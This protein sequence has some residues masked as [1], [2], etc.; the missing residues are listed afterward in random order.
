MT[1]VHIGYFEAFKSSNTLILEGDADG[2]RA[3]AETFRSLAAGTLD[4]VALHELPFMKVHHGVQVVA[5]RSTHDRGTRRADAE[6]VFYDPLAI[7]VLDPD[8]EDEERFVAV[9]LGS[10]GIILVVVYTL[11]G[12]EIRLISARRATRHEVKSYES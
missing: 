9:G 3:L 2:L 8:S 1:S 7:H 6:S 12:E 4:G 5:T 10:A 11:R